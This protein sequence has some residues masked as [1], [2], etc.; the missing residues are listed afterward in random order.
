LLKVELKEIFS[1]LSDLFS[2]IDFTLQRKC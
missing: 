1:F 2:C